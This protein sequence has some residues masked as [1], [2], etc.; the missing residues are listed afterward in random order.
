[1]Y[2]KQLKGKVSQKIG[3]MESFK[4]NLPQHSSDYMA[5]KAASNSEP[6]YSLKNMASSFSEMSHEFKNLNEIC[7]DY[8][9]AMGRLASITRQL[10]ES[11]SRNAAEIRENLAFAKK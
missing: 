9:S 5:E 2:D 11:L 3:S 7:R 8:G 10:S 4:T 1:M 6:S